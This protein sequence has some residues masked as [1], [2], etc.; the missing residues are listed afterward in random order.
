MQSIRTLVGFYVFGRVPAGRAFDTR[1]FIR[2]MG[3][4]KRARTITSIPHADLTQDL[5]LKLWT[6]K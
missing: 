5:K 3:Q 4:I 6:G 1:F 2:P